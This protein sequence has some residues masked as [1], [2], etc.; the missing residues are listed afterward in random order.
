[1]ATNIVSLINSLK[2]FA[3][4]KNIKHA[5]WDLEAHVYVVLTEKGRVHEFKYFAMTGYGFLW[6]HFKYELQNCMKTITYDMR[7]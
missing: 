7:L 6:P 5:C 3:E 2:Y 1:M 4:V